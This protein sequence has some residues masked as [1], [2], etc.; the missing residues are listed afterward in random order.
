MLG[1]LLMML[2]A[3]LISI[4]AFSIHN[5]WRGVVTDNNQRFV[6]ALQMIYLLVQL[7]LI[8]LVMKS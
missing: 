3:T 2:G 5:P 7:F 4:L 6:W 8:V 1:F